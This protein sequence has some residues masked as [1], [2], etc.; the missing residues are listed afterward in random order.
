MPA[1]GFLPRFC[2]F[3]RERVTIPIKLSIGIAAINQ[4]SLH[5]HAVSCMYVLNMSEMLCNLSL[6]L[7]VGMTIKGSR[8][9]AMSKYSHMFLTKQQSMPVHWFHAPSKVLKA[10]CN[11]LVQMDDMYV[12]D[13]L[14]RV[15]HMSNST[16][17]GYSQL[18]IINSKERKLTLLID[19]NPSSTTTFQEWMIKCCVAEQNVKLPSDVCTFLTL[20][21]WWLAIY[22]GWCTQPTNPLRDVSRLSFN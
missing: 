17:S 12:Y 20:R 9:A 4:C 5:L 11:H 18:I 22:G 1:S 19:F 16:S 15:G 13:T 10:F 2:R 14:I 21:E 8:Y 3:P 7:H 6:R